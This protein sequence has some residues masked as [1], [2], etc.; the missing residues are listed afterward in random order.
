VPELAS[1][2]VEHEHEL[3]FTEPIVAFAPEPEPTPEPPPRVERPTRAHVTSELE[4]D[5][6]RPVLEV[7]LGATT[8]SNL[9]V[10]MGDR[11]ADGGVFIATYQALPPGTPVSLHITLPGDL[12][13][14]AHAQVTLRR[15]SLDAF[16][17][18]VPGMCISFEALTH[19]GLALLERFAAKR[20]PLLI[21][22]D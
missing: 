1:A 9:Y 20:A 11:I 10:D 5:P 16:E 15:E 18:P 12:H 17:D 21:D 14:H 4:A 22:D 7:N 3:I 19:E 8:E 13:T 6:S 2:E